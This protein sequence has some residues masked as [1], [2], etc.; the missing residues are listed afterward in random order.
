MKSHRL[1]NIL[2]FAGLVLGVVVGLLIYNANEGLSPEEVNAKLK[3]LKDAG[4]IVLIRPL[5]MLLIPLV[6]TSVVA[7]IT[8][9]GNPSRLG[10]LGGTTLVYYFA[11]MFIAVV[12]GATLV[13]TLQP[14]DIPDEDAAFLLSYAAE[15]PPAV[16]ENAQTELGSVWLNIVRQIVPENVLAEAVAGNPLPVIAFSILFGLAMML[17]GE[18]A[19]PLID[20]MDAAF[21]VVMKLVMWV[22]W[23]TP[24]GVFLLVTWTIGVL[25]SDIITRVLMY[26]AVVVIGLAIH[27]LI[28]LP[29]VLTI[30]GRANPYRYMWQMRTALMTAFGTDSSSATLPVTMETAER[31][32][33]VSKKA[34]GFVLPLGATVNMD[35]TALYEAVAVIFLFQLA[36][37]ELTFVQLAVVALTATLAAVGAAG[38]PS[39]GVITMVIVITAVNTSL[40]GTA[41]PLDLRLVA[42]I[43]AV[44]RILDMCRTTVNVW[45]DAVGAKIITRIA[46]D[47]EEEKQEAYA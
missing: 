6:F 30:F 13:T 24:L 11:T 44:D 22:I 21:A 4:D 26:M 36:G 15:N 39:A 19:R 41:E 20:V 32:G 1:L 28:V 34:A 2:I 9:I 14:G 45:G 38:I 5:K 7:G 40:G 29:L 8:S 10:L 23:I 17:A 16:I 35:G 47:I 43:L 31:E 3:W 42:I 18:K 33:G 37:I 12:L 27:G 25:G 46:P